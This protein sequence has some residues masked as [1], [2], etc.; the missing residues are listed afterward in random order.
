MLYS[1]VTILLQGILNR[2]INLIDILIVYIKLCNVV[3]SVYRSDL[4]QVLEI[5][6]SFPTV[7]VV[8]NDIE[9]YKKI[10][11]TIDNE[12]KSF[13]MQYLQNSFYQICTTKKGLSVIHTEYVIK[14]RVDHF[15]QNLS[16]FIQHGLDTKK[17]ITSSIFVRGYKDRYGKFCFSDCLFMGKMS[18]IK[19]CFDLSYNNF[20]LTVPELAIW[21]PY[22]VYIFK[23][24]GID[25]LSVDDETYLQYMVELIDIYH[26]NKLLPYKINIRNRIETHI[27]DNNKTTKE[28]LMYGCDYN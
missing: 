5:C 27:N 11:V 13:S 23:M 25:I 19:L 21:K 10:P 2:D 9:E 28:Y 16:N 6:K 18:D 3:I 7:I 8:E 26:I 24:K 15:Y 1:N 4:P 17:I 12:F 22:F 20:L 14:T